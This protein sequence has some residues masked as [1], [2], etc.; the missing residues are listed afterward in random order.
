[1]LRA[2]LGSLHLKLSL[3]RMAVGSSRADVSMEVRLQD[4]MLGLPSKQ[5]P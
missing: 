1:M 3:L 2:D 5:K 4:E